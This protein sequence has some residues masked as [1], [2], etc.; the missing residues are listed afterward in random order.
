MHYLGK[1]L[2]AAFC[3]GILLIPVTASG[4]PQAP[5]EVP[6]PYGAAAPATGLV[7]SDQ[8]PIV[9]AQGN[10][11]GTIGKRSRSVSGAEPAAKPTVRT[12]S[13]GTTKRSYRQ[14]KPRAT[15]TAARSRGR[16][17][18]GTIAGYFGRVCY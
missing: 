14:S 8:L 10:A 11:G 13:L 15:R 9:L 2:L 1:C 16:C 4:A 5:K 18:S 17:V 6:V 3:G 7:S 12:R